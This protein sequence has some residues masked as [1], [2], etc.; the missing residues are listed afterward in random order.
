MNPGIGLGGWISVSIPLLNW[1]DRARADN[2]H[3][4]PRYINRWPLI[5]FKCWITDLIT[6][7]VHVF[8]TV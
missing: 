5:I 6:I 4:H 8:V 2:G 3:V 7:H 1:A